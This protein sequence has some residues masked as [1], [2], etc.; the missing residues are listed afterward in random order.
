MKSLGIDVSTKKIAFASIDQRGDIRVESVAIP[1]DTRAA[2]RLQ[3]VRMGSYSLALRMF[4][5]A[6]VIVVEVPWPGWELL[7]IAAVTTEAVQSAVVGAVVCNENAAEWKKGTVGHGN[8]SKE[9][10]IA[11]AQARGYLGDDEDFAAAV[12]MAE[13]GWHLWHRDVEGKAA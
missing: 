9:Q 6:C 4:S 1:K 12:C 2:R 3:H 7:S 10:Y 8:A 5:D 13:Y 11:H